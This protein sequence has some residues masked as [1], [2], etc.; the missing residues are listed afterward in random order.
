MH[1]SR[2]AAILIDCAE[3]D[4]ERGIEFWS[5]ALGK[6]IIPEDERYT[7]LRGRVGG[8]GGVI[9]GLQRVPREQRATHLDIE[10][11]DVEAEVARLEKLG[12][13]V[14]ARI[15]RHVVMLSPTDHAFCVVP[16]FREDFPARAVE[17]P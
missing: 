2:L 17:W 15:G 6:P 13:R 7:N 8:E 10:T 9:V 5:R 3:A 14:K 12:A 16:V 11:D 4:Y 1:R